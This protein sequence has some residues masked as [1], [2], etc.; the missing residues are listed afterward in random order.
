[1]LLIS[2]GGKY[3]PMFSRRRGRQSEQILGIPNRC[4]EKF[5]KCLLL[6]RSNSPANEYLTVS[7]VFI[8]MISNV[9]ISVHESFEKKIISYFLFM[10]FLSS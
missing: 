2:K 6:K 1:M 5:Q 8:F 9:N 3:F 4:S 7:Y 10:H